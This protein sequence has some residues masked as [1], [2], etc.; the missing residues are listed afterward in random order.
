[1]AKHIA[2]FATVSRKVSFLNTL[3][4]WQVFTTG[5]TSR[6][7][8][9][10]NLQDSVFVTGSRQTAFY[11]TVNPIPT[12]VTTNI[13]VAFVETPDPNAPKE[14]QPKTGPLIVN[15]DQTIITV[16]DATGTF[17]PAIPTLNPGGFNPEDATFDPERPKRSAVKL[18]TVYKLHSRPGPQFGNS[19]VSPSNQDEEEDVPYIYTL[20]LPTETIDKVAV[21]IKGLY[22]VFLIAAPFSQSWADWEGN[23][24]LASV[25]KTFPNWYVGSTPIMVD[26]NVANCLNKMRFQFLQGVMCGRCDGEYFN[27]YGIYVGMLNAMEAGEWNVATE[28]YDRLKMIC[29][30]MGCSSSCGSCGNGGCSGSC[31][32]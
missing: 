6:A 4:E 16:S 1:M 30:D 25:A 8:I 32:C 15:A 26:A 9:T 31:G 24:N 29:A 19:T 14:L 13:K 5:G 22:E 3:A 17:D 7:F 10:T 12:F 28:Y 2:F 23:T 20:T 27:T 18:W 11:N 21:T